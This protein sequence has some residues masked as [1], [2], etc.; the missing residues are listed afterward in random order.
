MPRGIYLHKERPDLT[1]RNISNN[2]MKNKILI[3][4]RLDTLKKRGYNC[5]GKNNP[6]YGKTHSEKIKSK[7]KLFKKGHIPWSKNNPLPLQTKLKIS[8]KNTGKVPWNKNMK[9]YNA[10]EKSHFWRG[11]ITKENKLSRGNLEYKIWRKLVFERDNY[12]CIICGKVGGYLN[13]HHIKSFSK[14][15]ELRYNINNGITLCRD[16]HYLDSKYQ[17]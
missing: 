9:G 11:G 2:P 5:S 1:L 12:T 14:Y 3:Q 13:V 8:Q 4:K 16:C 6:F 17:P 15:F 10:G 7:L